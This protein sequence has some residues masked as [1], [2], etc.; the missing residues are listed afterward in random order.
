M[1]SITEEQKTNIRQDRKKP[2]HLIGY[3]VDEYYLKTARDAVKE[4]LEIARVDSEIPIYT[5][6]MDNPF[7]INESRMPSGQIDAY[8]VLLKMSSNQYTAILTGE[9]INSSGGSYNFLLGL[10]LPGM[11]AIIS[12]KRFE[13][14]D[15]YTEKECIKTGTM[16]ETG[17]IFNTPNSFTRKDLENNIGEHCKNKCVMRQGIIVPEDWI[18]MTRDRL[19]DK[20]FC[21]SCENDLRNHFGIN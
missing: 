14:L 17:H 8:K 13:D 18:K 5:S 10:T 20:P 3:H 21:D 12:T 11:G 15:S 2:F 7:G 19:E 4:V 6:I 16:H 9:D 1:I